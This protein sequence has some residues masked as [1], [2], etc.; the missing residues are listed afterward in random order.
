MASA[1]R[2]QAER[3]RAPGLPPGRDS[4]SA[5]LTVLGRIRSVRCALRGIGLMLGGQHNA[6]VNAAA[7]IGVMAA[8]LFF[9]LSA[10]EWAAISLAV[11]AVWVA[12]ALNTA[13]EHLC[14][15]ASPAFHPGVERAKDVAAG[16]VVIA[17][18]G[19]AI[20]G[21]A[22]FGPRALAMMS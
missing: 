18:A 9:G 16:A 20:V 15:V 7:T 14:D 8:G 19:A 21:L 1:E 12:E 11:V 17:A 6:W 5:P 10:G 2:P 4:R 13:F 3:R 22:V